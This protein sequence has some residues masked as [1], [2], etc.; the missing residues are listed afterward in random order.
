MTI[1]TQADIAGAGAKVAIGAAGQY[2][3]RLFLCAT[4]GAARFGD[5]NVTATRGVELPQDEPVTISASDG[6]IAD[7]IT[8]GPQG[9]AWVFAPLSTTVTVSWGA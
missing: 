3:R 6:D 9:N 5:T 1:Q 2:A 4:G 7:R 8:L